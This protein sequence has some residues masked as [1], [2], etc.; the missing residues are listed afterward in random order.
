ME[1]TWHASVSES[2]TVNT[3]GTVPLL[4]VSKSKILILL[5]G[6]ILGIFKV[7]ALTRMAMRPCPALNFTHESLTLLHHDLIKKRLIM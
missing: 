4:L 1:Q 5:Q 2:H 6:L 7:T 3:V